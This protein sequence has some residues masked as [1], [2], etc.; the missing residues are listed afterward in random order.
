[1]AMSRLG[2]TENT[3][4]TQVRALVGQPANHERASQEHIEVG[5]SE[6]LQQYLDTERLPFR[7]EIMC[8]RRCAKRSAGLGAPDWVHRRAADPMST[9]NAK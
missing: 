7:F 8:A 4:K 5:A 1:M 3:L 9:A 6:W 2:T